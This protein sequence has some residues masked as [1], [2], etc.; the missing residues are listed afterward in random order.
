MIA[1]YGLTDIGK[2]LARSTNTPNTIDWRV[3]HHLDKMKR[4]TPEQMAE[5]C[6]TSLGQMSA[7]L[8]KLKSRRIVAEETGGLE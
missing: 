7:T 5:Y 4:S 8:R 1:I 3:V 6:G 2:R